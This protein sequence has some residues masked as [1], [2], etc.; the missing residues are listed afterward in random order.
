MHRD[1]RFQQI[2]TSKKTLL[3]G[4]NVFTSHRPLHKAEFHQQ[5]LHARHVQA[6]CVV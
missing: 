5:R 6:G 1:E 4:H 2:A 3:F